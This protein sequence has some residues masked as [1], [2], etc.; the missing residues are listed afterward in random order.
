MRQGLRWGIA[1]LGIALVTTALLGRPDA[2][3]DKDQD[4]D[5]LEPVPG[6]LE[7]KDVDALVFR[8]LREVINR[9]ADLYNSGDMAGCYRLYEGSLV[10]VRPL[11][12][13]R[14]ELQKA[15]TTGVSAAE[16]D[17][18]VWR[19]AFTLRNVLDKIRSETNPKK[20]ADKKPEEDKDRKPKLEEKKPRD[21]DED[22]K[23]KEA[24][25]KPK[26]DD[27][28]PKDEDKKPKDEDKKKV[29]KQ[30]D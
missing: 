29:E 13:H 23:P 17:A 5:I 6:P 4:K 3:K 21:Q 24:V 9:G 25:K 14:P 1:V 15:I 11:L 16:R 2:S 26:E 28:K 10:S 8:G 12:D 18:V 20:P 19:R 30:D 22:R 27:E 7:R